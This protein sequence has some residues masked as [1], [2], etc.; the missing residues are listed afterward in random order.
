VPGFLVQLN[1]VGEH[2]LESARRSS[3]RAGCS[4]LVRLD[5]AQRRER[6]LQGLGLAAVLGT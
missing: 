4:W 2:R 1:G 6:G 5:G 3:A